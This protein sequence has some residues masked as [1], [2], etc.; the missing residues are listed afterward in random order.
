MQITPHTPFEDLPQFL[1]GDEF[2]IIVRIGRS[3]FYDAVK[4]GEI[5]AARFGRVLRIPRE[6]IRRFL[7]VN[8]G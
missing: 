8:G 3:T 6:E 7:T 2:R 5:K 1:T 4:R